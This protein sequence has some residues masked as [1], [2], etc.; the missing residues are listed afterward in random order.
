MTK[1]AVAVV[2]AFVVAAAVF[3][4]T[5]ERPDYSG[6]WALVED[7]SAAG[8]RTFGKEFKLT[9][10]PTTLTIERTASVT[11]GSVPPGGGAMVMERKDVKYSTDFTFDGAEH[12]EVLPQSTPGVAPPPPGAVGS[13]PPDTT[14]RATWMNGQL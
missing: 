14:Y 9:Q 5:Q 13:A 6:T 2:G 12:Q 4:Q 10:S 7:R 1:L 11:S 8:T 3:G